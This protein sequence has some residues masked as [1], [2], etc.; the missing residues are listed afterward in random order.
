MND[1]NNLNKLSNT[2]N[3][4]LINK[5]GDK[6]DEFKMKSGSILWVFIRKR[7]FPIGSACSG[8]G[9]CGACNIK[10]VSN[11]NESTSNQTSFEKETLSKNQKNPQERLACLCRVYDDIVVQADYW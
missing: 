11:N 2:V 9:V 6:I 8:V 7:G 10:I 3:V 4:T 1:I 5:S